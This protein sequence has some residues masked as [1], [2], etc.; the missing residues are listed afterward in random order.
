MSMIAAAQWTAVATIALAVFAVVTAVFAFLAYRKQSKEL[1]AS[2]EQHAR[3]AAQR[4]RGQDAQT[5]AVPE[6]PGS[7]QG[8]RPGR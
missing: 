1:R 7:P 4:E 3:E 8:A 6:S 2:L 5:L